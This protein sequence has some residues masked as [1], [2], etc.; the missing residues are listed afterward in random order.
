MLRGVFLHFK[1]A[2]QVACK[3]GWLACQRKLSEA[4]GRGM[5]CAW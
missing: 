2:W 3:G 5:P 1:W 4:K